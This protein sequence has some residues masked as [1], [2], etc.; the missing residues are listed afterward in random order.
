MAPISTVF[1]LS[2]FTIHDLFLGSFAKISLY[3]LH[4]ATFCYRMKPLQIQLLL[5]VTQ[6]CQCIIISDLY[7]KGQLLFVISI[8]LQVSFHV[9]LKIDKGLSIPLNKQEIY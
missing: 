9:H 5:S 3:S 4:L 8:Y 2:S 7:A 1:F 6:L